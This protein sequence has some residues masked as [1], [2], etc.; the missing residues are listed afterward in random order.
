MVHTQFQKHKK[1]LDNS[2]D[3]T[4]NVKLEKIDIP[5]VQV[6]GGGIFAYIN[7][8]STGKTVLLRSDIDALPILESETNL[9]NKK[10]CI[11]KNPGVMHGCGHDGHIAMLL[12][13]AKILKNMEASLNGRVVLMFEE[14]EEGHRNIEKLLAY[15]AEKDMKFDTCYASH[16][17]WDIPTGNLSCCQGSAM[18]GLYHFVLEING[19]GGHGSRPD[20]AHSVIDC[21]HDIYSNLDTLRLK[22][23]KPNTVLT[24]SLGSVNAGAT[25]NLIPDKLTCEGSIR[26]M[27]RSSGEEFIKEFER[28]VAAICPLNYC[29]YQ[30]KLLEQL[31]PTENYP[32][33]RKTY[34][35]SIKKQIGEDVIYDCEPWMASETFSYMCSLFPG[36]E[37]FVGI[38]NDEL[39]SGANHHTPEFDLDEDGLTYGTAAA[40]SYVLE[41]FENTPD[42]SAFEPAYNSISELIATFGQQPGSTEYM[43]LMLNSNN[44]GI[45]GTAELLANVIR[46]NFGLQI[47]LERV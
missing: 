41:Y 1:I 37:T 6:P 21:F 20:L 22:Y 26:M 39:G 44:F 46:K 29:T 14:G 32:A 38:K 19:K 43:D 23:I 16:V 27:D 15:M 7:R 33:C 11:S 40:V 47:F 9:K 34:I 13:A 12:S 10:V 31:L 5:Y 18:S 30:F 8:D 2:E 17:R 36:V 4:D 28:I 25:F 35:D 45:D 42:T 3:S 24:W